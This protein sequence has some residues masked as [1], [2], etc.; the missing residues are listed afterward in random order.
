MF[1]KTAIAFLLGC[2]VSSSALVDRE[3]LNTPNALDNTVARGIFDEWKQE[4]SKVYDAEENEK[5]FGI[6]HSHM[7]YIVQKNAEGNTYTVGLNGL[8]DLTSEEYRHLLG[9]QHEPR[10]EVATPFRYEDTVPAAD[11]D[12]RTKNAVTPIKNQGQCGSCWAFSTTGSVEGINAIKTGKLVAF[13]EE[14]LVD[15]DK[16]DSGCQGGLMDN[17]FK[18]IIQ[19][20]GIDTEED[21]PYTGAQGQCDIKKEKKHVGKVTGYE[22]V[23]QDNENALKKAATNQPVSVAIEADQQ[24]FQ[25][26]TGGVFSAACGTQLDHGV[27]VVGYGTE[28]GEH[29]IVKNSW[30]PTWGKQGYILMK[31]HVGQSGICGIASQ[32]SYPT[33]D[34]EIIEFKPS[35]SISLLPRKLIV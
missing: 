23:P 29:W 25:M 2:V 20:G 30:G 5:R 32:P 8:A 24:A 3:L 15:C 6:F 33:L 10:S 35:E 31:M 4:N 13:S 21:Y 18:W 7:E 17:A 11:V 26:Y 28:G 1:P 27:L 19:N 9:Y 14:E 34:K 16:T 22:D 12:W